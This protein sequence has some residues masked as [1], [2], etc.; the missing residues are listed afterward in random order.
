MFTNKEHINRHHT[1]LIYIKGLLKDIDLMKLTDI[2]VNQLHNDL[3]AHI[4][5]SH[6]EQHEVLLSALSCEFEPRFGLNKN[7]IPMQ[8]VIP[9]FSRIPLQPT[10]IYSP[11]TTL[12]STLIS[13]LIELRKSTVS[14]SPTAP[15]PAVLVVNDDVTAVKIFTSALINQHILQ[16]DNHQS[17]FV[18][19]LHKMTGDVDMSKYKYAGGDYDSDLIFYNEHVKTKNV[20]YNRQDP[21]HED[22][23]LCGQKI[24]R[25]NYIEHDVTHKLVV[26]GSCCIKKFLDKDKQRRTCEQCNNPHKNRVKNLCNDCFPKCPYCPS[27]LYDGHK[28]Y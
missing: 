18:N 2:E 17:R 16:T 24:T 10:R 22:E 25:N 7:I 19:G 5:K 9:K 14:S 20:H 28:C 12:I 3:I 21:D 13:T 23:C 8:Q 4:K 11:S 6:T 27:K 15:L 1:A 26:V